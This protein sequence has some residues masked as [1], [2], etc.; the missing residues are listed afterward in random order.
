MAEI[1][2]QVEQTAPETISQDPTLYSRRPRK[3]YGGMWGPLEIGAV[4]VGGIVLLAAILAYVFF[5]VPSNNSVVTNRSEADRLEA[6]KIAAQSR[7]GEITTTEGQVAKLLDSA[8]NFELR[9]LPAADNGRG[10]LYQRI[11][12][13]ISAYGLVNTSGPDY[14]PLEPITEGTTN[15]QS[16][17][18]RGRERFRSLFP[19]V[20]VTTTV[21]GSYQNLRRFIRDIETGGEFVVISAIELAPSDTQQKTD[22]SKPPAQGAQ[23]PP[24]FDQNGFPIADANEKAQPQRPKGKTHGEVVSLRIEMAAYF[25]RPNFAPP[26]PSEGATQ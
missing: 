7:Y 13:L 16:Q 26:M 2:G 20:Y 3:V 15:N 10:A 22:V 17:E 1:E 24:A 25:R 23:G 9:Y 12:G 18:E 19:G 11:N 14:Q 8:D 5:V 6:E 4:A 21:E